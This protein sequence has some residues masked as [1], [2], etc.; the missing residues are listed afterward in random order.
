MPGSLCRVTVHVDCAHATQVV[1]LALPHRA[2]LGDVLPSIVE[3]VHAGHRDFAAGLRWRLHRICG[4]SL[5]ESLSLLDNQ[6][7]DGEVLWLSADDVPEPAFL[8]RDAS[9]AVARL[10]PADADVPRL[11]CTG[12]SVVAAGVG[13]IAILWSAGS[14]G[15]A[16]AVFTGAALTGAAVAAALVA[17]RVHPEPLLCTTFSAVAAVMAAVTGAVAVPGGPLAAHLLLASSAA[18][19]AAVVSL[20][21]TGRGHMPLAAIATASLLCAA[22][23]AAAVAWRLGAVTSGALLAT[24]ALAVLSSAPRLAVVLTRIGP[25]PPEDDAS[26]PPDPVEEGDVFRARDLLS[27][28]IAGASIAAAMATVYVVCGSVTTR[29]FSM[30]AAAFDGVVGVAL[31][32]RTRTHIG[33]ARRCTLAVCG[34]I[35]LTAGF[36]TLAAAVPQHAHWFGALATVTGAGLLIPF[37]GVTPGLALRRS[38][39]LA[40]YAALAAVIP[41]GCWIAGVFGLVRNLALT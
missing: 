41:L 1:D 13:S 10:Q 32:L 21:L 35:G 14:A 16:V 18:L 3:L 36:G 22:S 20:R 6:V 12:G 19:A 24:M 28:M 11:L 29:E 37:L 33:T 34:F 27:G 39:E 15:G 2:C 26:D 23:S 17:R 4:S 25:E 30:P 5:D 31:L 40:E 38:A 7:H 8:D 9:R